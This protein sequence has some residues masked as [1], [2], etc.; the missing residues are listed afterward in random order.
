TGASGGA[1]QTANLTVAP[2]GGGAPGFL[3]PAANAADSGGDGNGFETSP[4]NAYSADGVYAADNNSGSGTSTSCTSSQK[5]RHRFY[6]YG[7]SVATGATI[8]GLEVRLDARADSTSGSPKMCV[9]LSGDGGATW[10]AAKSTETLG[11][12]VA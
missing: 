10:T 7:F 5:D 9:Q 8:K 11:T 6:N 12:S 1:S 3:S 2:G 4:S